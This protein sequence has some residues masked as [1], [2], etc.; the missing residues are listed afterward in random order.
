MSEKEIVEKKDKVEKV[1][2]GLCHARL[3]E[4]RKLWRK[5]HPRK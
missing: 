5:D 2:L 3:M 1:S 4:E